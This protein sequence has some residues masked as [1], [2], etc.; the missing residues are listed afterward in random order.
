VKNSK[1]FLGMLVLG[2]T[3]SLAYVL[4][5]PDNTP[6]A[7]ADSK[8]AEKSAAISN[9]IRYPANSPQL[10]YLQVVSAQALP[11]PLIEPLNGRITYDENV[12]A[13]ISS[14]I[15]GRILR[16][17]AQP[18]EAVRA[19]QP[20]LW[21][22]APEYSG[23]I[24]DVSKAQADLRQKQSAYARAKALYEG[25]VLARKDLESSQADVSQSEAEHRRAQQRLS[26]LTRGMGNEADKYVLRSTLNGVVTERKV[27]PGSEVRPDAP[28]PL[29]VVTDP[30]HLW[31][32]IDVPEK[33]IGKVAV[34]QKVTLEADAFPGADFVGQI[35]SI[36]EV[37]D[38]ATRRV[39]VRCTIDNPQRRLKPEMFVRVTPIADEKHNL[40]RIPNGAIISE[41]LYSFVFVQ[42][43]TGLFERRRVALGLQGREES[44]V[45]DGIAEGE[46]IVS[47][48]ALLLNAELAGRN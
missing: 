21:I 7:P 39:Q 1:I 15:A 24:A 12:T 28:D 23:A 36:G 3:A 42:T 40:V 47:S 43:D 48:G 14:P 10:T 30:T 35:A 17:G 20:L 25:E 46:R 33:Y 32:I 34:G 38:P 9:Q 2:L 11:E 19:G 44:Y 8:P 22:D 18:G 31:V 27:N 6:A 13:R 45:K 29:F 41:G 37:L 16:I 26:N 4:S 5:R